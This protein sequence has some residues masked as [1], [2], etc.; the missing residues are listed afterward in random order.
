MPRST[1]F[2]ERLAELADR[3]YAWRGRELLGA[4]DVLV[5]AKDAKHIGLAFQGDAFRMQ[6]RALGHTLY[7]RNY[8]LDLSLQRALGL[9]GEMGRDGRVPR[10][11]TMDEPDPYIG[12]VLEGVGSLSREFLFGGDDSNGVE[13]T[14]MP[15]QGS[16]WWPEDKTTAWYSAKKH[17]AYETSKP[18]WAMEVK[19]RDGELKHGAD[20]CQI[21]QRTQSCGSK[22]VVVGIGGLEVLVT[23]CLSLDMRTES[24]AAVKACGGLLYPSIAVSPAPATNFGH[25]VLVAD[26]MVVLQGLKPYRGRG[27]WPVTVYASDS[28]TENTTEIT[29]TASIELFDELTGNLLETDW[30][31][32]SNF[33]VLGPRLQEGQVSPFGVDVRALS[34]TKELLGRLKTR[35]KRYHRQLDKAELEAVRGAGDPYPFLEAKANLIVAP[36]CFNLAV[37]EKPDAPRARKWLDTAGFKGIKLLAITAPPVADGRNPDWD[38]A[39]NVRDVVL[40]YAAQK[41]LER[42]LPV[43]V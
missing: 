4:S 25:L 29:G 15:N 22:A 10:V 13:A 6:L 27:A 37:C 19:G 17:K 24:A 8:D 20:F 9:Y 36:S 34:S 43:S 32:K 14:L 38:F 28:W 41:P 3:L 26:P 16:P 21:A 33:W 18:S 31:Y 12:S 35:F 11:Q 39:W 23:H 5:W 7:N 42:V 30:I 2:P 40:E 1:P